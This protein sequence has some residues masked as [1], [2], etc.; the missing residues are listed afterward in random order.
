ML[1]GMS[2]GQCSICSCAVAAPDGTTVREMVDRALDEKMFL[3]DISAKVNLLLAQHAPGLSIHRSSIH[4]H[5][6]KCY[7][8][9]QRAA[10]LKQR[11]ATR[12]APRIVIEWPDGELTTDPEN[13]TGTPPR[14]IAPNELR[15]ADVLIS[16]SFEILPVRNAPALKKEE[17]TMPQPETR[18]EKKDGLLARLA[19]LFTGD[20][21]PA[22]PPAPVEPPRRLLCRRRPKPPL[23]KFAR[24]TGKP[25]RSIRICAALRRKRA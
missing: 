3:D 17:E 8:L 20:K 22:E 12:R 14:I 24:F 7:S 4:R 21:Q 25:C 13:E 16:V 5:A 1:G 18:Q 23:L 2:R 6:K 19:R 10:V 15:E 9:R 11:E